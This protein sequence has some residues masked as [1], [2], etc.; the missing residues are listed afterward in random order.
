MRRRF[1]QAYVTAAV[2]VLDV[3]SHETRLKLVLALT[4][5]PASVTELCEYLDLPQSNVSHHLAL[6]RSASLVA[7]DRDGQFVFYHLSVPAWRL[8]GDGFFDQ[9]LG[10]E[11]EVQ[12]QNILIRRTDRRPV[13]R[14]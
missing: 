8:L 11:N 2:R 12:L 5:G 9:L 7:D 3:L 14:R 4:Q 6:L 13:R 10:G 1:D